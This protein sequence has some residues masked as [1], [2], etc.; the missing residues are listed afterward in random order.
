MNRLQFFV[1][2][3]IV[4]SAPVNGIGQN[5][6]FTVSPTSVQL[7]NGVSG[8]GYYFHQSHCLE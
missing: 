8:G 4:L 6:S 2:I 5:I 1:A 7:S 3:A